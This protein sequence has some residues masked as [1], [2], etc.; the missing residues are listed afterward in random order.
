MRGIRRMVDHL[1]SLRRL[2]SWEANTRGTKIARSKSFVPNDPQLQTK[3]GFKKGEK[4]FV[5]A[6]S[7]GKW[8]QALSRNLE[9]T[10]TDISSEMVQHVKENNPGKIKRFRTLPGEV[11]PVRKGRYDWSFSFEPIPL[12]IQKGLGIAFLHGLLNKKGVK[13]VTTQPHN[14]Y[15]KT[16]RYFRNYIKPL[17]EIYGCKA[18]QREVLIKGGRPSFEEISTKLLV[19][20][21]RTNPNAQRMVEQDLIVLRHLRKKRPISEIVRL[22]KLK[23]D[24]IEESIRRLDLIGNLV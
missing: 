4:I 9:V 23:A 14:M 7:F 21:L 13:M 1:K 24:L 19:I 2:D 16:N 6:G 3:L 17:S 22:T 8:S 5:F 15:I 11:V 18:S 12:E 20:T 10:H